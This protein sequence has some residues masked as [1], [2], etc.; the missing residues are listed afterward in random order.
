VQVVAEVNE[1][2]ESQQLYVAGENEPFRPLRPEEF[3]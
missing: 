1:F 3:E 2:W